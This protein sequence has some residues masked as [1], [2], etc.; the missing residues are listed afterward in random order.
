[1]N[2]G[3]HADQIFNS[4]LQNSLIHV[5]EKIVGANFFLAR[6]FDQGLQQRSRAAPLEVRDELPADDRVVLEGKFLGVFL[7]E[8]IERD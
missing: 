1:L 4:L 8:K 5:H 7:Q 6:F 2:A 3:L